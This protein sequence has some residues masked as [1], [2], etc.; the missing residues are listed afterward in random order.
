[1]MGSAPPNTLGELVPRLHTALGDALVLNTPLLSYSVLAVVSE[2]LN[3]KDWTSNSVDWL[4][5]FPESGALQ[6]KDFLLSL[7]DTNEGNG[8]SIAQNI[9]SAM[10]EYY[11][12][13]TSFSDPASSPLVQYLNNNTVDF[14]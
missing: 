14:D 9:Y 2:N 12:N 6:L 5:T 13:N 4:E 3:I 8:L 10:D 1:M 7:N 11:Q